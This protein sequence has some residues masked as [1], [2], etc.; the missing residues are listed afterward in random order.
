VR[1]RTAVIRVK[2]NAIDYLF[3]DRAL[4][5]AIPFC[6]LTKTPTIRGP[7][8]ENL[9]PNHVLACW[10]KGYELAAGWR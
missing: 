7:F 3:L 2:D 5:V 4:G 9:L 8:E 10:V 6:N 1:F